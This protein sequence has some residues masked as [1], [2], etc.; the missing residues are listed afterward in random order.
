MKK[1]RKSR[2]LPE[3]ERRS[4]QIRDRFRVGVKWLATQKLWEDLKQIAGTG[5]RDSL[6]TGLKLESEDRFESLE[7]GLADMATVVSAVLAC[8][9]SW[10]ELGAFPD[11]ES[12]AV[13]GYQSVDINLRLKATTPKSADLLLDRDAIIA[14][15]ITVSCARYRE[16]VANSSA[17]SITD[18]EWNDL[19]S[20]I[21]PRLKFLRARK[22]PWERLKAVMAKHRKT[23]VDCR[24]AVPYKW[25]GISEEEE[26]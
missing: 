7:N 11:H 19:A 17:D 3:D 2:A 21:A 24:A 15:L 18:E 10:D 16:L 1:K 5:N 23:V 12:L 9:A 14:I 20:E 6:V 13:S 4:R 8:P 22:F 25:L 26:R